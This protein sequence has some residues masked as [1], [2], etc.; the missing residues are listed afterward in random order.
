MVLTPTRNVYLHFFVLETLEDLSTAGLK[1]LFEGLRL[2]FIYLT[3][4]VMSLSHW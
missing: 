1:N 2:L 3:R 4:E